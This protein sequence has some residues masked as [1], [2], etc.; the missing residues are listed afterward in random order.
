MS[1]RTI[2]VYRHKGSKIAAKIRLSVTKITSAKTKEF[3]RHCNTPSHSTIQ[4]NMLHFSNYVG[5]HIIDVKIKRSICWF[6]CFS[7]LLFSLLITGLYSTGITSLL[8]L[9]ISAL[10]CPPTYPHLCYKNCMMQGVKYVCNGTSG[11]GFLTRLT[12]LA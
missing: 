7:C 9:N 4:S 1:L 2:T 10:S 8:E 5:T 6:I 3:L 11:A 12:G